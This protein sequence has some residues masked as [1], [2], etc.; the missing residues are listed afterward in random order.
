MDDLSRKDRYII[1]QVMPFIQAVQK[2]EPD[3][4]YKAEALCCQFWHRTKPAKHS[5]IGRRLFQLAINGYLPLEPLGKASD[6]AMLY[7]LI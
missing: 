3:S 4:M 5:W 7:R 1:G 2:L 6:K